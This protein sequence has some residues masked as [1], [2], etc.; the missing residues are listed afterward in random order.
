[1]ILLDEAGEVGAM[2]VFQD[3]STSELSSTQ[4]IRELD[5]LDNLRPM[6]HEPAAGLNSPMQAYAWIRACAETTLTAGDELSLLTVKT[7]SPTLAPLVRRR[8]KQTRL[9]ILGVHEITEPVD[10]FY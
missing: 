1:M 9:E 4:V 3:L 6:W 10:F 8:G 2:S 5:E 7:P